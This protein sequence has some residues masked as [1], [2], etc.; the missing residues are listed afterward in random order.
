MDLLIKKVLSPST[1]E[2]IMHD[3]ELHHQGVITCDQVARRAL[4]YHAEGLK[5]AIR[6][7]VTALS[8]QFVATDKVHLFSHSHHIFDWG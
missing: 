5:G 2:R 8:E 1:K 3:I 4:Q 6:N 7:E